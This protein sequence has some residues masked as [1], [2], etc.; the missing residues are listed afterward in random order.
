MFNL[1]F[2]STTSD[3]L[4]KL[5]V[6]ADGVSYGFDRMSIKDSNSLHSLLSKSEDN[7]LIHQPVL[8]ELNVF[9]RQQTPYIDINNQGVQYNANIYGNWKMG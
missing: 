4:K 8:H 7:K 6:N 5:P 3:I 9:R 2:D 1:R